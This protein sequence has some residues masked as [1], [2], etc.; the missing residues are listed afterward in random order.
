MLE[1]IHVLFNILHCI[2]LFS[3]QRH[4]PRGGASDTKQQSY[5]VIKKVQKIYTK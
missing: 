3:K 2:N 4:P 1:N 5:K